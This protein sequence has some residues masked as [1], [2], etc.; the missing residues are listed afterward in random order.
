M[1][2]E[3]SPTTPP[4]SSSAKRSDR[5]CEEAFMSWQQGLNSAASHYPGI[6]RRGD[7]PADR[8]AAD[9]GA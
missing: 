3:N 8:R 2:T 5:G 9:C 4:P 6:H 7:Q 1:N